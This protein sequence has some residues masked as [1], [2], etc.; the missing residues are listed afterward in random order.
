MAPRHATVKLNGVV[1]RE[2]T[3]AVAP[4]GART[5]KRWLIR[6]TKAS[7]P[8]GLRAEQRALFRFLTVAHRNSLASVSAP[9]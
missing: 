6:Y 1:E 8:A 7:R 9:A 4:C 3:L 2:L 5:R